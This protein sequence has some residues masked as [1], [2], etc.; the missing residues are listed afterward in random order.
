MC[1]SI[2]PHE[3]LL[4]SSPAVHVSKAVGIIVISTID[5]L[6]LILIISSSSCSCQLSDS[7]SELLVRVVHR[8]DRG[9]FLESVCPEPGNCY[10]SGGESSTAVDSWSGSD[11]SSTTVSRSR[12]G[13][14]RLMA[15]SLRR[16]K[17]RF[18][19]SVGPA[20]YTPGN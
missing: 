4:I 13:N 11:R 5:D 8:G 17:A 19:P 2:L 1:Y 9:I 20:R 15:R 10:L 14:A 16:L 7:S 18:R 6:M 3:L 12:D